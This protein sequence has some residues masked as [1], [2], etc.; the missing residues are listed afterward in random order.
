MVYCQ[1]YFIQFLKTIQL[2]IFRKQK[3]FEKIFLD[4]KELL[5]SSRRNLSEFPVSQTYA[6]FSIWKRFRFLLIPTFE[7]LKIIIYFQY[8]PMLYMYVIC[9]DEAVFLKPCVSNINKNN[10]DVRKLLCLGISTFLAEM[11]CLHISCI[12]SMLF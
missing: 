6:S 4:P 10:Q 12:N 1:L 5:L 2:E 11:Q 8:W 7:F 3:S 9:Y